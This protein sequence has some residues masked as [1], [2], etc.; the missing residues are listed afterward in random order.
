M[1]S[2]MVLTLA[3][4]CS[5]YTLH[6]RV[7]NRVAD[8]LSR[9]NISGECLTSDNL[10]ECY[11][12]T[13]L[14]NDLS[15]LNTTTIALE[16]EWDQGLMWQVKANQNKGWGDPKFNLDTVHGVEVLTQN[17]KIVILWSLQ[18]SIVSWYHH[19]L[20][21]PSRDCMLSTISAMMMW[22]M[23]SC[24]VAAHCW[25]CSVCQR[26]KRRNHKYSHLLAKMAE[27][28]PWETICIYLIS[29]YMIHNQKGDQQLICMT[30]IDSAT[31]WSEIMQVMIDNKSSACILQIFNNSWLSHYLD[32]SIVYTTMGA[33][34]NCTSR[35]Y[36]WSMAYRW[37]LL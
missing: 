34:L 18:P 14:D 11:G 6:K 35:P 29:P 25:M 10:D 5:G 8:A 19:W 7:C 30:M 4:V 22:K 15:P 16:Q 2:K 24:D 20:W 17:D 9:L 37:S 36:V 1:G 27:I 26:T 28:V 23:M 31:S 13:Q 33:N 3:I 21:H 32:L 12:P